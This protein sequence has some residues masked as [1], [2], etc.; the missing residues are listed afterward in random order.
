MKRI[1]TPLLI[2]SFSLSVS[3]QG[4]IDSLF[5]KYQGVDGFVTLN[6]SGNFLKMIGSLDDNDD[7]F[8][9]HA[10][11]F[12]AIRILA[13]ENGNITVKNFYREVMKELNS[14]GYEEMVSINS[15]DT[16]LKIMVKADGKVFT[17]FLLVAGGDDNAIIQVKG[18]MTEKIIR[19]MS[20]S[21]DNDNRMFGLR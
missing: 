15:S 21:V 18:K 3:A 6:V 11:K 2:L 16:D 1:I 14:G 4:S 12:T 5:D 10:D 20:E 7:E 17:E 8:L 9:K 19:E 13:Q